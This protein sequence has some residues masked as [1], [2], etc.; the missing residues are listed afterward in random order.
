[1]AN[2]TSDWKIVATEGATVD[3]RAIS[4]AWI[5]DMATAY[6][7]EEYTALIWPE[8]QRSNWSKSEGNNWGSVEELKAEK[9]G[10]KL[11]LLAKITPNA[12][13]LA[14]NKDGQKLFTSI[15]PEPDYKGKGSCYL[16]GLAVTDS[17]ASSGT[18]RLTFSRSNGEASDL[19]VSQLEEIDFSEC[20]ASNPL[21]KAFSTIAHFFETEGEI[22][23]AP[24]TQEEP[25]DQKQ[26]AQVLSKLDGIETKQTE[27]E[28][29]VAEFAIKPVI[30]DP[31][32]VPEAPAQFSAEQFSTELTKQLKPLTE[33]VNG[34]ETKFNE[35]SKEVP[36]Q[37]PDED[38]SG[39]TKVEAF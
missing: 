28:S 23:S 30:A 14:A 10:G 32:E 3:G 39:E 36:G 21:A 7:P 17:P 34:L 16:M 27:L 20:R 29:K 35:L 15:E 22:P 19:D 24:Q 5:K 2:K 12:Y 18:T 26:F 9:S 37:R 31:V 38:G 8:H 11:R 13:L 6:S 1:M 33:K 25:M 4:S